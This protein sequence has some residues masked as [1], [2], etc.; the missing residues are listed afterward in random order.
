[1]GL[2]CSGN[3]RRV[4]TD[5]SDYP[6]LTDPCNYS[7]QQIAYLTAYIKTHRAKVQ[8][9]TLGGDPQKGKAIYVSC[10]PCHQASGAGNQILKS[11]SLLG[12]SDAYIVAQLLKFKDGSPG[13]GKGDTQGKLMQLSV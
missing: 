11:P 6:D 9:V 2:S 5:P 3:G 8:A 4:P 7:H 13:S 10:A 1:M 12:L